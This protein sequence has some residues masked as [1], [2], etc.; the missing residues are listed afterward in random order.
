MSRIG[1]RPITVPGNV[2][3]SI[4]GSVVVVEGPKGAL[5]RTF[6]PEVSFELEG[7]QLNVLRADDSKDAR[8]LHGLSRTLVANM[9]EGVSNGFTKSLEMVGVGYRATLDG[10]VLNLSVGYS[11]PVKIDPP[12]GIEIAVEGANKLHVKGADKQL[13][14][15]VAASIRSVR[16]PE[17]YKGKGI[18]YMGE[19][20]R[21]K[22]GKSGGKKK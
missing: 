18:K 14:G 15:D 13:V 6:L 10:R 9:V 21:R 16:P 20:I 3:V 2:K 7:N 5:S 19:V 11:H 1:K 12:A 22:A 8:S 17:P 4:Q